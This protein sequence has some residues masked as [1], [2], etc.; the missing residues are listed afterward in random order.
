M[1][2]E[3]DRHGASAPPDGKRTED[4]PGAAAG[5]LP[6]A[7]AD[8]VRPDVPGGESGADHARE[9]SPSDGGPPRMDLD[10]MGEDALR[11]L[12][13]DSVR[14]IEPS[15]DALDHLRRAVPARRARRR[16]V[17][18]GAAAAVLACSVGVPAVLHTD[19]GTDDDK[20][21]HNAGHAEDHVAQEEQ[22]PG[23]D[24]GWGPAGEDG[25]GRGT[26]GPSDRGAESGAP[27]AGPSVPDPSSSLGPVSPT[28]T[29]D[30]LGQGTPWLGEADAE[31]RVYGSFTVVNTSETSCTV[32]G[33]GMVMAT[34][35]GA[36]RS[37]MIQVVDH[38]TGDQAAGLP[39][40]MMSPYDEV[41]LEPDAAYVVEFA[42]I[43]REG[44][45]TTGCATG[46]PTPGGDGDGTTPT[47]G[48]QQPMGGAEN[49]E[50]GS[51]TGGSG[52]SGSTGGTGGETGDGTGPGGSGGSGGTSQ[53][54]ASGGSGGSGDS[55]GGEAPPSASVIVAHTPEVG[56]PEAG[57]VEIEGA[58]AGTLY[59]TG[60]LPAA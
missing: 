34:A 3:H 41:V 4:V 28:C 5:G 51:A 20:A 27:T 45:G 59:R 24:P 42:W 29:R 8:D 25:R 18:V 40:P 46:P 26:L 50:D 38:T 2:E 60:A 15:P 44:G 54:G 55:G 36:A 53:G 7:G 39:D 32:K 43:P 52:G 56:E 12:L 21:M 23:S 33:D 14:D 16:Q 35:Q 57:R 19:F 31:G 6:G 17:A 49:L 30:Q 22:P 48:G 58:C 47:P 37:T 10:T 1:S 11:H 13:Q 9:E